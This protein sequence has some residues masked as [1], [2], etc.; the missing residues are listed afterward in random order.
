M[1]LDK[2]TVLENDY[3]H[4]E[5]YCS[6]V[7]SVGV[8]ESMVSKGREMIGKRVANSIRHKIVHGGNIFKLPYIL[9]EWKYP[10]RHSSLQVQLPSSINV[11]TQLEYYVSTNQDEFVITL[12]YSIKFCTPEA[13]FYSY[14]GI[15]DSDFVNVNKHL[16][17]R[18]KIIGKKML[19]A[20][21]LKR[22]QI[23]DI[24]LEM[25]IK[26]QYKVQHQPTTSEDRCKV[27]NIIKNF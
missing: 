16:K 25:R 14:L 7:S 24:W 8:F 10:K 19:I 21:L 18:A 5:T 4:N 17:D 15:T 12:P 3:N 23:R 22:N 27:F 11:Y 13:V 2:D 6:I 26:L 9:N 20:K 1:T